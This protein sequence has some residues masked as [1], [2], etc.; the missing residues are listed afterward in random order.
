MA[1]DNS[2]PDGLLV[3]DPKM[4]Y[5]QKVLEEKELM[6]R[7]YIQD[8]YS[9]IQNV[10]KELASLAMEVKLTA[11]PKK[12][13]LEHLRKLIEASTEKIK[14]ARVKEEQARKVWEA[15]MKAVEVEEMN[16][17]RL[18]DDLRCLVQQ[19]AEAQYSRLEELTSRLEALNPALQGGASQVLSVEPKAS[20]SNGTA[21]QPQGGNV[22][23]VNGNQLPK[24]AATEASVNSQKS[25]PTRREQE[26]HAAAGSEKPS[27]NAQAGRP[28][29]RGQHVAVP[30]GR[31]RD[32]GKLVKGP[33]QLG[34]S[35]S[36]ENGGWTGA[37]FDVDDGP[38]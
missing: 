29:V 1:T 38:P 28:V 26:G 19:S 16:K 3:D 10:E 23:V 5:T 13:A 31:G 25:P 35:K 2:I 7:K 22:A 18:C 34:R 17:Q 21:A 24:A 30:R 11:G 6:L 33:L 36:D 9:K 15:T 8:N 37:G 32:G 12:A 20:P 4:A 14:A 27:N